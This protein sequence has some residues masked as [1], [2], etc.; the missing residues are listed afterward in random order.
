MCNFAEDDESAAVLKPA[1]DALLESLANSVANDA[2]SGGSSTTLQPGDAVVVIK[3]DLINLTGR[4]VA[5]T[6]A[7]F[8]MQ[9]TGEAVTEFGLTERLEM[10]CDEVMKTFEPGNR[11]KILGGAYLGETGTVVKIKYLSG[12]RLG[13]GGCCCNDVIIFSL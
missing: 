9:P 2:I 4:V 13:C 10:P 8:T 1:E 6:G 7:T 3:G 12:G 5:V 11:V